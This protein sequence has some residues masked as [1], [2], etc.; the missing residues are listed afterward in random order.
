MASE[1]TLARIDAEINALG[2]GTP[3]YHE[4]VAMYAVTIA[5]SQ[6][7]LAEMARNR[8]DKQAVL[9]RAKIVAGGET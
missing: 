3:E 6:W 2:Y 8:R 4:A 1:T 5:R 9:D 7:R